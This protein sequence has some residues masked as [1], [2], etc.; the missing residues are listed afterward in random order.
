MQL[1]VHV[2]TKEPM[3]VMVLN[4]KLT[5][6]LSAWLAMKYIQ[7]IKYFMIDITFLFHLINKWLTL[8]LQVITIYL[9][10][11]LIAPC[12][13]FETT[14]GDPICFLVMRV[15]LFIK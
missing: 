7:T 12:L 11:T 6:I 14:G 9:V 1:I 13:Y 3:P 15:K 5:N 10:V 8:M 4:F 2:I